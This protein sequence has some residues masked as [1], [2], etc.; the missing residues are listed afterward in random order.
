MIEYA[1]EQTKLILMSSQMNEW[2]NF[3]I[4]MSEWKKMSEW[5]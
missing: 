1:S 2:V 3:N 4:E 5:V